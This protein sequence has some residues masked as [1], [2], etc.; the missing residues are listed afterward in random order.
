[1]TQREQFSSDR[2]ALVEALVRE[3]FQNTLDAGAPGRTEPIRMRI[4]IRRP[5]TS[6]PRPF[7]DG[8]LLEIGPHLRACGIAVEDDQLRAPP[9]LVFEDFNTTGLTGAWD[10]HDEGGWNGFFRAFGASNKGGATGGRWGLG[11]LVFTSASAIR[12][13]FALTVRHD[14]DPPV[15]L[16]MGQTI[17]KTHRLDDGL[18]GTHGFL[19]LPGED[20]TIQLPCRD[21][22]VIARFRKEV[23][24]A[25]TTEPGLS[26]A[27]ALPSQEVTPEDLLRFLLDNY[28]FPI[29]DGQLEVDVDGVQ[30]TDATFD[31]VLEKFGGEELRGGRMAAFIRDVRAARARPCDAVLPDSWTSADRLGLDEAVVEKLRTAYGSGGV[32]VV[33]FPLTLRDRNGAVRRTHVDVGV[34]KTRD[35]ERGGAMAVR[36]LITVPDE[37]RRI[38]AAGNYVALL[39]QDAAIVSFLG[40]AEGPAHMEWNGRAERLNAA[41][42]NAAARLSEVRSAPRRLLDLLAPA[43]REVD[44]DALID[45]LS[46]EQE[47]RAATQAA[48]KRK[49]PSGTPPS[50]PDGLPASR[51]KWRLERREGGFA[52]S[53]GPGLEEGDL[54]LRL[55][56]R[57]AFAVPTGDPF[58]RHSP[59]DF[60][61]DGG[62][63]IEIE[64]HG[65]D[66]DAEDAKTVVVT[67]KAA[68]FRVTI[69]GFDTKRD[70]AVEARR[71][72]R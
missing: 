8:L 35:G 9:F 70:L 37:A 29:L 14:D 2:L 13:F 3:A 72:T 33:R 16:L 39:A 4:H 26:V 36:G 11:K 64:P 55:R 46:I 67:A 51:P 6:A 20:G 38:P 45:E 19:A 43:V 5:A 23:G 69:E 44:H 71:L 21:E 59:L 66:V 30:V 12:T 49:K 17:L 58:T 56:V 40:D 65:A 10:R 54:P 68:D 47:L 7:M 25:R 60:D 1:M 28:F 61:L 22:A 31:S 41:W 48:G 24:V 15:P 52:I 42:K 63:S 62:P 18:Y 32:V 50:P 57:A 27:V 53:A 34:R